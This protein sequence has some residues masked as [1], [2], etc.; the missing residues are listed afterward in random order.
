M[1]FSLPPSSHNVENRREHIHEVW[2]SPLNGDAETLCGGGGEYEDWD[3][4]RVKLEGKS[5]S[6][7]L[8]SLKRTDR[9]TP[10]VLLSSKEEAIR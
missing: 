7:R 10:A 9:K 6:Q 8:L 3:C 5:S 2:S 1:S 4:S